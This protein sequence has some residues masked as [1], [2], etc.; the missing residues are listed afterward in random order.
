MAAA[1]LAAALLAAALLAA[2]F[3]VAPFAAAASAASAASVASVASVA[4]A[5]D[6][7]ERVLCKNLLHSDVACDEFRSSASSTGT[8]LSRRRH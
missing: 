5:S 4:F 6:P 3:A 1:L 8:F 2:T 7:N